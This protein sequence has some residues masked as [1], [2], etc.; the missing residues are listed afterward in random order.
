MTLQEISE[1]I[2][3][4]IRLHAPE[5]VDEIS[6]ATRFEELGMDSLSRVDLLSSAETAFG[7]EVPDDQVASL[8]RVQDL[9][10]FVVSLRG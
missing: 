8:V 1:E 6:P 10:D 5:P 4:I 3:R 7:I 9:M 2:E